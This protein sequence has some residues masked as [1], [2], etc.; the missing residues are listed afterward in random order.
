MLGKINAPLILTGK[1]SVC[2]RKGL[3]DRA[4]RAVMTAPRALWALQSRALL[5]CV[6]LERRSRPKHSSNKK[7]HG[8][9]MGFSVGTV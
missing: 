6:Q 2:G 3:L 7:A 5:G 4:G 8:R 1:R 9:A